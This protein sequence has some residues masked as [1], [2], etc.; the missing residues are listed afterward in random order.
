[1]GSSTQAFVAGGTS[2]SLKNDTKYERN[3]TRIISKYVNLFCYS[4]HGDFPKKWAKLM[5]K[6]YKGS[7]QFTM[8][9]HQ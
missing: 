2:W 7:R 5:A 8:Q 9:I 4:A 6:K 3:C 1:M